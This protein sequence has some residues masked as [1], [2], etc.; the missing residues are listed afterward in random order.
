MISIHEQHVYHNDL[1]LNNIFVT[2]KKIERNVDDYDFKIG[3]FTKAI[4]ENKGN[5]IKLLLL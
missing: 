5:C 3:G 4:H 1:S 2:K